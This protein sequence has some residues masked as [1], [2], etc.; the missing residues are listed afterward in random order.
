VRSVPQS[1]VS[2]L[3]ERDLVGVHDIIWIRTVKDDLR[4]ANINLHTAGVAMLP[5]TVSIVSAGVNWC[6]YA[7]R[8]P[9]QIIEI[10]LLLQCIGLHEAT[11]HIIMLVPYCP[12]KQC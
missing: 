4:P 11:N 12:L 7:V 3:P 1:V 10:I 2:Q 8:R 6:L 9:I 5:G